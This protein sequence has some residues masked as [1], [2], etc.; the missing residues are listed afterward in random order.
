MTS[1][2]SSQT[3]K[4]QL[5]LMYLNEKRMQAVAQIQIRKRMQV[6]AQIQIRKRTQA[7]AQIQ[8]RKRT[9]A[10]AQILMYLKIPQILKAQTK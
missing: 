3:E 9:Q 4:A 2:L 1:H 5:S 10:V 6:V 7:V 8:I